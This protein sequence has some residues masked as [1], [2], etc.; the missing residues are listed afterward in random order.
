VQ[1]RGGKW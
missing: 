1:P